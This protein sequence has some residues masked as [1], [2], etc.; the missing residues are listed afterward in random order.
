MTGI[1]GSNAA[2]EVMPHVYYFDSSAENN[3]NFQVKPSW[4]NGLPQVRG[5]YGCPETYESSVAEVL[6]VVWG[7]TC[8]APQLICI[9]CYRNN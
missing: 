1:Y 8:D 6:I 7:S 4:V 5:K 3:G 9:C 2:G